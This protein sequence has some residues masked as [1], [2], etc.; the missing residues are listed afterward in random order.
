MIGFWNIRGFNSPTKQK[1]VKW[2]LHHHNVGLFGLLETK[3]KPS[4]LNSVRH[5]ICEG[6]CIS[7]NTQWHKGGRVWL[8]WKPNLYQIHFIVYNAQFIHVKVDELTTRESFHLTMIYAFNGVQERKGLWARLCHFQ[9]TMSGPWL[10]YGDFN[11]IL[12]PSE[13]LGG[14]STEEEMDDF[15]ICTDYCNVVDMSTM[16]SYFTWNNKHEANTRVFSRLDR[17]LVWSQNILGTP[18]FQ[19]LKKLKLLKQPLKKLNS[20]LYADVENNTVRAWK[21]LEFVQEQLRSN[22]TN[23]DLLGIELVSM[24]D[25]HELQKACDSF[26]VEKS[27]VTWLSEGESNTKHFHSY[28]RGRQAKNIV[29]RIAD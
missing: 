25:Y 4:S 17:A 13:R 5:N 1:H 28:M 22:P 2:F 15:Q 7:T 18:M 9:D 24:K 11:T 12:R 26:L 14:Q 27:K 21:H 3:V 23:A 20:E 16:G 10:I 6:W 29:L 19:F 8:I